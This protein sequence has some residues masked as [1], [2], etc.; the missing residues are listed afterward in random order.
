MNTLA[1]QG[2]GTRGKWQAVALQQVETKTGKPFWQ[3]YD[4]VGGTSVGAILGSLIAAGLSAS[5]IN[6]FFDQYAPKIFNLTFLE[7][8]ETAN[9]LWKAAKYDPTALQNALQD[10]LGTL[11]LAQCKTRFIATA[12]DMSTGKNVYFQSYGVS[13][14]SDDEIIIGPDSGILL[15]QVA[16]ASSAAQSYFPGYTWTAPKGSALAGMQ[17]VFWDGGSTGCNAPD[18]L[19]V[20]EAKSMVTSLDT[21]YMLSLGAG[22]TPW[23]YKGPDMV[24]PSVATV[25]AATVDIAYACV[26]SNEVWQAES[27]LGSHYVRCNPVLATNYAIDDASPATLAALAAAAGTVNIPIPSLT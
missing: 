6:S 25:I 21:L 11:T 7:E 3:L 13:S 18:M 12:V 9:R 27:W 14:V 5:T 15:W 22:K 16:R 4:L 20:L 23:P 19:V 10:L 8:L 26:E 24:N 2:G 17:F 1:L